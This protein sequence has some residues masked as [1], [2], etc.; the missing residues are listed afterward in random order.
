MKK[1][2]NKAW[3]K[4]AGLR[5]IR[6]FAQAA[7]AAIG[8]NAAFLHEVNWVNVLSVSLMAAILSVLTSLTGLPEVTE[9]EILAEETET[10]VEEVKEE[11]PADKPEE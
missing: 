6:T 5:A 8:T 1:I 10:K 4:A 7:L 11:E 9:E 2:F 3:F